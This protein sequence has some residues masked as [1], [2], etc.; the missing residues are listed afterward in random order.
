[1]NRAAPLTPLLV[2]VLLIPPG[3][4]VQA[5]REEELAPP[6]TPE[7]IERAFE[8]M[9]EYAVYD[10]DKNITFDTV[11]AAADRGVTQR[12]IDVALDFAVHSNEIVNAAR[13]RGSGP[14]GP[15]TG[16]AELL[17][18]ALQRL[19][20]ERF[21]NLFGGGGG[22]PAAT[23]DLAPP[24]RPG[25]PPVQAAFGAFG[26]AYGASE[27]AGAAAHGTGRSPTGSASACGGGM[28]DPH[29]WYEAGTHP[30]A[31]NGTFDGY[32]AAKAWAYANG[33]HMVSAYA[34]ENRFYDFARTDTTA[35]GGCDSGQF[36]E[37]AIMTIDETGAK[38]RI[39]RDE[40]NPELA[41]YVWPRVWWGS[42]TYWWH[43]TDGG[44]RS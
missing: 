33:Y 34:T 25:H 4:G 35:P 21:R 38:F 44:T 12:D 7:E 8:V 32:R 19:E 27:A 1:M 37:Q 20:G 17:R 43:E 39:Q 24:V 23:A 5:P 40:P 14:D 9:E 31:G 26:A 22:W 15:G 28:S 2:I 6:Y 30:P 16:G 36:R 3:I 11:N 18:E 41:G 42:Y 10:A 13:A 29:R